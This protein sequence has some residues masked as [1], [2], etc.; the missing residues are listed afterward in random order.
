MLV[1]RVLHAVCWVPSGWLFAVGG[2][3]KGEVE[4]NN[5]E[6]LEYSWREE[7]PP[8][9][10]KWRYVAPLLHPRSLHG[11]AFIGG[12]LVAA[13]G[14]KTKSVEVFTLPTPDNPKGQWTE[15]RPFTSQENFAGMMPF[16]GGLL[17]VGKTSVFL[18]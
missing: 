18:I 5:V 16:D 14:G 2:H 12:K 8:Q 4:I 13:G 1:G 15:V 17:A 6:M 11:L 7:K 9:H 10:R 3:A